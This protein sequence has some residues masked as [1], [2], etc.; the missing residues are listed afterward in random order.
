[1][2]P[3]PGFEAKRG[4]GPKILCK[5]VRPIVEF[6]LPGRYAGDEKVEGLVHV[7]FGRANHRIGIVQPSN[8]RAVPVMRKRQNEHL[9]AGIMKQ[10]KVAL[11][12]AVDNDVS[13][14]HAMAPGVACFVI[15]A[16]KNDCGE[17]LPMAVPRELLGRD[18][19][20]PARCSASE[21]GM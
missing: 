15:P 5:R 3:R 1:M 2:F 12:S 17:R 18:V 11:K 4:I 10:V 6:G 13:G 21:R 19:P 20:H 14:S 8:G 16:G 7:G 9:G